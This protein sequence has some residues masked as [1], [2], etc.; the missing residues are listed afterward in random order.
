MSR[1][2]K[3]ALLGGAIAFILC[4]VLA[5]S[6]I[7]PIAGFWSVIPAILIM[8]IGLMGAVKFRKEVGAMFGIAI[9]MTLVNHLFL[10][11]FDS[12][13]KAGSMITVALFNVVLDLLA[14]LFLVVGMFSF[15]N[16]FFKRR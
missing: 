4:L 2:H 11:L 16:R 8:G 6:D 3:S 13:S 14:G 12:G 1:A 9:L 10:P 5:I 15:T 7:L